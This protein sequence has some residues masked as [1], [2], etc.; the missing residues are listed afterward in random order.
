M[1]AYH[2]P[3]TQTETRGSTEGLARGHYLSSIT[4]H[5]C[6]SWK[7]PEINMGLQP[8]HLRFFPASGTPGHVAL[9]SD[10]NMLQFPHLE[11]GNNKTS[12][13]GSQ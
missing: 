8:W 11:N 3:Q 12:H 10:P 6:Q 4:A 13:V 1:C 9:E 7:E 2:L 5:I